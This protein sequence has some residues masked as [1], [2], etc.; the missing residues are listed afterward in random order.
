MAGSDDT[1]IRGRAGAASPTASEDTVAVG[2][3]ATQDAGEDI[4]MDTGSGTQ[5][6]T[7]T[8]DTIGTDIIAAVGAGEAL[9]TAGAD[10]ALGGGGSTG[11]GGSG[12]A[13][14]PKSDHEKQEAARE[15]AER[16]AGAVEKEIADTQTFWGELLRTVFGV[17]DLKSI[18]Q[19]EKPVYV[20]GHKRSI[21]AFITLTSLMGT[22]HI[23]IEQKKRNTDMAKEG[24]QSGGA[25]LSPYQ[26]AK[27]YADNLPL[28]EKPRWIITCNFATFAVY[29]MN[30]KRPEQSPEEVRLADL[31]SEW[32]RLA[33]LA[34]PNKEVAKRQEA[35]SRQ[36]GQLIG[37]LHKL[38]KS[39][40]RS[41]DDKEAL[42]CLN[43]FCVRL[44]FCL[45][46][47]FC[48]WRCLC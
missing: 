23:L 27:R 47:G 31:G 36:T 2:A 18:I 40:M 33:F 16:W 29:D 20:D 13:A 22:S 10:G 43:V 21:D 25:M 5:S 48:V 37:D 30:L 3:G 28:D 38:M 6:D 15:F 19:F 12:G 7:G 41:P 4:G 32:Y 11:A 45:R 1:D 46:E 17:T 24:K 26:Q 39:K 8:E 9:S 44:V 34:D 42:R 35:A 14:L